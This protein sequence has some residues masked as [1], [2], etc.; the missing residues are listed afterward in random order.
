LR[1]DGGSA[2]EEWRRNWTLVLAASIGF[3]FHSIMAIGT[4]VFMDPLGQEF[5]WNR[6][7]QS[8]GVSI[9]SI[10]AMVLSPFFGALIDRW[11]V[12]R[13]ALPGLVLTSLA[14]AGFALTNGSM[15]Q[16]FVLWT[17]YALVSLAVKS[18]VWT[19]AV[20]GVFSA[21]RGLAI[22]VTLGGTALA[23]IIVP[24]LANWLIADYGWRGAFVWLGIGWGSIA[25]ILSQLF[26]FDAHDRRRQSLRTASGA[27]SEARDETA[28]LTGLSIREAW[29]DQALWRIAVSTFV[30][31]VLTV[32]LV[33]HQFPLLVEAGI[34]R[35]NAA[36]LA[37]LTGVAGIVG[38][39]VTGWLLD[40]FQPN[41]VGG[42]TLSSA[43]VAFALLMEPLRSPTLIV[44]AMVIIGYASGTKL[45]ICGYLTTRY[46]GMRNFG[47]IFGTMAS[48]IAL[49]SGLGPVLGGFVYD[50]HGSY[51]PFLLAGIA[52]SLLSGFLI[53]GLG[54]YP[55][56]E[57][58]ADRA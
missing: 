15:R 36:I 19:A 20:A 58:E 10:T 13:L 37:S 51:T 29:R 2:S 54:Q 50:L 28:A 24:P 9:A 46:G 11:G 38:K 1:H 4:G 55:V 48:I 21:S 6:A 49:G 39:L 44:V 52:G 5:G 12:R 25:L 22:G 57:Q 53:F 40:R 43:A 16:W 23:Q 27:L 30:I 34:T 56:W 45:Q 47:K 41:W 33:V 32:A 17:V 26:L 3:S 42:V 31:M 35:E 8:S 7:Q 14:I 18:T